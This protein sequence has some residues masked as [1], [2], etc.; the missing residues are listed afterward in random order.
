MNQAALAYGRTA[1]TTMNVREI[2]AALLGQCAAELERA[3]HLADDPRALPDALSRNCLVWHELADGAAR[4]TDAPAEL[5]A[6]T[7]RIARFVMASTRTIIEKGD[8]RRI[9]RLI[10][11]NR[12]IARGLLGE[13]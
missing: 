9:D 1:R 10:E 8:Q 12:Q 7:L 5:R 11:V 13:A 2:E 6:N 4:N 3:R